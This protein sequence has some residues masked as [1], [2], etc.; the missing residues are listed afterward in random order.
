MAPKYAVEDAPATSK[1][2]VE[3][4]APVSTA[5]TASFNAPPSTSQQWMN[6]FQ[7]PLN[8]LDQAAQPVNRPRDASVGELV[9]SDLSNVLAGAAGVIRHPLDTLGNVISG[10]F[11]TVVHP[12]DTATQVAHQLNTNGPQ[13]GAVMLGQGLVLPSLVKATEPI[14]T[15]VMDAA[16][17]AAK[18]VAN[19]GPAIVRAGANVLGGTTPKVAKELGEATQEANEAAAAKATDANAKL[20]AQRGVDL[21]NHFERTQ[22]VRAQN[23]AAQGVQTRKAALDRGVEQLD[24]QIQQELAATRAKVQAQANAN[25]NNV[26]TAYNTALQNAPSPEAAVQSGLL[27]PS[28]ELAAA[29]RKAQS[30]ITGSTESVKQ[31]KDIL[32]KFPESEPESVTYQGAEIPQGHPL[33]DLLTEG[34]TPTTADLPTVMGYEQEI[35]RTLAQGRGQLPSDVYLALKSLQTDLQGT[36]QKMADAAG[37]GDEH[38]AARDYYR[39]YMQT[40]RDTK[41]P[42]TKAIDSSPEA[43]QA[44]AKFQGKDQSGVEALAKYNPDLAKKINTVRGYQA[45]AKSIPAR[46]ATLKPEPILAP[47]PQPIVPEVQKIGPDEIRDAKA[48]AL[49]QQ[50]DWIRK[51][52]SL[53]ASGYGAYN[54]LTSLMHGNIGGVMGAGTEIGI[55]LTATQALATALENPRIVRYLTNPTPSDIAAIPPSVRADM[56]AIV[57]A[58]R[59][60]GINVHPALVALGGP[61]LSQASQPQ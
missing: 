58:A 15:P 39:G 18:A 32:S 36:A 2:S 22:A 54:F 17:N 28:D 43:G 61:T 31:F 13:T 9:G 3:D 47:K 6:M 12:V 11:N 44:I 57:Q 8:T 48:K 5:P 60:K 25:Y 7:H 49:E 4:S 59:A 40:F 56:P 16:T 1:Y 20:Q 45:K 42:I 23:E 14:T 21:Q 30:K 35:G 26:K 33:Y 37:V 19:S 27:A 50:A 55:G 52:G 41:S 46:T 38:A 51:R 29:V 34:A 10:A 24:P 53:I